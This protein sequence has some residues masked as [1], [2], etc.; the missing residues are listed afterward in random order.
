[1]ITIVGLGPG[2]PG[3]ITQETLAAIGDH[4]VRFIRTAQHPT[5]DLVPSAASFDSIY[6]QAETFDDVYREIT[7]RLIAEDLRHG[8]ILYAVPGSP[9]VLERTVQRLRASG[10]DHRVLPAVS[11]LDLVWDRLGIDPIEQRVRLVDGHTFALSAA[12]EAGPLLVAHTHANWVLSDIKL[13][14][15]ADDDQTAII[16]QGL[17]TRSEEIT[18][19]VWSDLDR[20][21]TADHLTSVYIPRITAPVAQEMIRSVEVMHRLRR[22]CPWD[23]EQTHM[24]LRR[25]LLEE[26]YEVLDA[27]EGVDPATG[28]GYHHLE[29]ELG[30]LWFQV[31]FHAELATEAGQFG[32]ADVARGIHDKLVAR[33]PHVFGDVE[34]SDAAAVLEHWEDAKVSEKK[35]S[36]VMDGIPTALPALSLAEKILGKG[37]RVAPL[38]LSDDELRAMATV[39]D[40][41]EESIA[42]ALIALVEL[43]RRTGVDAEGSLRSEALD[44]RHRFQDLER[45]GTTAAW[46]LG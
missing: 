43:A 44:A 38:E 19:V 15:D 42:R 10:H 12:G 18:E 22:D 9:L 5:G 24:S 29:E 32:I 16:L 26:T 23:R 2:H 33:H 35:R 30:D 40:V 11:F 8:R 37:A 1:M 20:K 21:L 25:H 6:D 41:N 17:G 31:L 7:D 34:A 36:S 14:I 46:V 13:A 3:L 4:E 28:S 27:I 45:S 39:G